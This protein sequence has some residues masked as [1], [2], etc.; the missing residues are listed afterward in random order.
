MDS[1]EKAEIE[2][3][4]DNRQGEILGSFKGN[5]AHETGALRKQGRRSIFY[6]VWI[7]IILAV[8]IIPA[9]HFIAAGNICKKV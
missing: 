5:R 4:I 9:K 3:S 7:L 2:L 8:L 6:L 1:H